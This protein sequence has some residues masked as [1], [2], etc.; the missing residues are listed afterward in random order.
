MKKVEEAEEEENEEKNS[1]VHVWVIQ[2]VLEI[3]NVTTEL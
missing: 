2:L 1:V 3:A